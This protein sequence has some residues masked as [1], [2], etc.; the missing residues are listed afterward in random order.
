[1]ERTRTIY[2]PVPIKR[3]KANL[4][5][6]SDMHLREDTPTCWTGDFQAEQ[7]KALDF[8]K[9]LQE[10]NSCPVIHAGDLCHQWKASP[11]LLRMAMKHL[12]NNFFSI[13]GQ[14]DLPS[15][16]WDLRDKSGIA[17]LEQAKSLKVLST[18]HYGQ[19]PSNESLLLPVGGS[20]KHAKKILVWHH[21]TYIQPPFPGASGGQAESILRKYPYDLIICGDNHQSFSTEYQ[22]RLLVNPG[23][24][25]RQTAD[26]INFQPR[27]ALWYAETNTIEWVNLPIQENVISREHLEV[28]E[29]RNERIDAFISKLDGDWVAGLSF[30]E[31]LNAF[32]QKNQTRDSVKQI[33][34]GAIE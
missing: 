5:I 27:V 20:L 11:W 24:M 29:Q 30:E 10:V 6:C 15:H 8:I 13:Y 7:W 18:C 21:M 2:K 9:A 26:Q 23:C 1:M 31:N 34:Y 33:I 12:P 22:G 32:F 28:K 19:I 25:T 3:Q 16:N 4:I 17:A 14:H